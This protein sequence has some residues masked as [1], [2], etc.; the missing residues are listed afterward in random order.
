MCGFIFTS[1]G[2]F[3]SIDFSFHFYTRYGYMDKERQLS[4]C[5]LPIFLQFVYRYALLNVLSNQTNYTVVSTAQ[6]V[7]HIYLFCLL[8]LTFYFLLPTTPVGPRGFKSRMCPPY[9]H[10]CR[11]RRLKWGAVI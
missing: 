1:D 5:S 3:W 4:V 10:T 9:P 7:L 6:Y 11:K 8:F 2:Y